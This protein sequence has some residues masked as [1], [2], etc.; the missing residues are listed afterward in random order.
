[1]A[2]LIRRAKTLEGKITF[3]THKKKSEFSTFIAG[4][5]MH[6]GVPHLMA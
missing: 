5:D 6:T 2:S 3:Q 1:M 4:Q